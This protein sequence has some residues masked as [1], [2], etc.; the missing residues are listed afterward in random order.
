MERSKVLSEVIAEMERRE[1]VGI[2]KYKKTLD[3]DDLSE[4]QFEQH[5]M[6]ELMDGILYLK[7]KSLMRIER[8]KLGKV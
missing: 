8:E 1:K 7:K 6:E 3:R 4:E 2:K 5:L